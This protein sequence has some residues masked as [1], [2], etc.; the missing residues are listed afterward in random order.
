MLSSSTVMGEFHTGLRG[1][2]TVRA[3][4][5]YGNFVTP[6]LIRSV[7]NAENSQTWSTKAINLRSL[8]QKVQRLEKKYI[9]ASRGGRDNYELC[10]PLTA[11]IA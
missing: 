9:I 11:L 5:I 3:H 1:L 10:G 6:P 2:Y 7:K 8:C 4:L